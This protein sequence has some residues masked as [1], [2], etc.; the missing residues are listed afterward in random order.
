MFSSLRFGQHYDLEV[1]YWNLSLILFYHHD[2]QFLELAKSYFRLRALLTT[3]K[4]KVEAL[5]NGVM[6]VILAKHGNEQKVIC[7]LCT[8][9]E[10]GSFYLMI[11]HSLC[12]AL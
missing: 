1:K 2:R 12:C 10:S 3:T 8:L 6:A 7:S 5:S 11:A 9:G 4:E